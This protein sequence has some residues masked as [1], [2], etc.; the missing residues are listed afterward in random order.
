MLYLVQNPKLYIVLRAVRTLQLGYVQVLFLTKLHVRTQ[1]CI[2]KF[3]WGA[4]CSEGVAVAADEMQQVRG[5][6]PKSFIRSCKP[7]IGPRKCA[8]CSAI[9][10]CIRDREAE[11]ERFT[12]GEGGGQSFSIFRRAQSGLV[13][14]ST[15]IGNGAVYCVGD[16]EGERERVCEMSGMSNCRLRSRDISR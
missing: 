9:R 11:G 10:G 6:C 5:S 2:P 4:W 13:V 7:C 15:N 8:E 12:A 14:R 16:K 1:F 3:G